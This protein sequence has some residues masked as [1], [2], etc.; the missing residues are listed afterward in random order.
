MKQ[1]SGTSKMLVPKRSGRWLLEFRTFV[2]TVQLFLELCVPRGSSFP[3]SS[4]AAGR[5]V[6]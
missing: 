6:M 3:F 4:L 5:N 2:Q 1:L